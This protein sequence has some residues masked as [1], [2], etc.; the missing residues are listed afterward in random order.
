[1]ANIVLGVGIALAVGLLIIGVVF[2]LR[3]ERSIV[4]ERLGQYLQD[5]EASFADE[6]PNTPLTN[7]I[8]TRV[9]GSMLSSNQ[10]N[11]LL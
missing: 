2:S 7:W 9:E 6:S 10:V 4:D 5:D 8:N 3:D 1:M 11:T